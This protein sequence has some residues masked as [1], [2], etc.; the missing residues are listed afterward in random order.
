MGL[1]S[2]GLKK[3]E[4]NWIAK[5]IVEGETVHKDCSKTQRHPLKSRTP[6]PT[7]CIGDMGLST[8]DIERV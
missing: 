8:D 4:K 1:I 5:C 6:S 7:G 3:L 2:A